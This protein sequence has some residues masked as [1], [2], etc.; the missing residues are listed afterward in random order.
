MIQD[1]EVDVASAQ[2]ARITATLARPAQ[3]ELR[4]RRE[5]G[6]NNT[7]VGNVEFGRT[8]RGR[9]VHQLEPAGSRKPAP[10]G[11]YLLV[12]TAAR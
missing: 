10:P 12:L 7:K 11:R 5:A 3:L 8:P 2:Q 6:E 4:V 1:F 9:G